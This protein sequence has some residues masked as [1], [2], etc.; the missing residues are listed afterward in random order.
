MAAVNTTL[1]QLQG[2]SRV[3]IIAGSGFAM[4]ALE[5][6]PH[7]I[8]W[9]K[10]IA[11]V[12]DVS[13]QK[14]RA[15]FVLN[16]IC[17]VLFQLKVLDKERQVLGVLEEAA[18]QRGGVR[19]VGDV[20]QNLQHLSGEVVCNAVS[21]LV[22]M[23]HIKC[24]ATYLSYKHAVRATTHL[25]FEKLYYKEMG[26]HDKLNSFQ[27]ADV[28]TKWS[29]SLQ[30]L[31]VFWKAQGLT[32]R[33]KPTPATPYELAATCKSATAG[34]VEVDYGRIVACMKL[35]NGLRNPHFAE[36]KWKHLK[37]SITLLRDEQVVDTGDMSEE[38][39]RALFAAVRASSAAGDAEGARYKVRNQ[40]AECW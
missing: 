29:E 26:D 1:Q 23:G 3:Q 40:Y 37:F 19:T 14:A 39:R 34:A 30:G 21:T 36:L 31:R 9:W 15:K 32:Q 13:Q 20:L 10:G 22:R 25:F 6:D 2:G 28:F 18:K 8:D 38:D 24:W 35:L 4:H 7:S 12:Q 33:R 5:W 27:K 17:C 11:R 16:F